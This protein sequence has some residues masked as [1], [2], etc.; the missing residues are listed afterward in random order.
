MKS[1]DFPKY[2]SFKKED[3]GCIICGKGV[4]YKEYKM[5]TIAEI[6]KEDKI[7]LLPSSAKRAN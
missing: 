4:L 7:N 3:T 2:L 1:V 5:K 6:V